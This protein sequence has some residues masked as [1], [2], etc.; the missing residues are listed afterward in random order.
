MN[1]LSIQYESVNHEVVLPKMRKIL[2]KTNQ[3][4]RELMNDPESKGK[5]IVWA[6]LIMDSLSRHSNLN[7][8]DKGGSTMK[9]FIILLLAITSLPTFSFSGD[10]GGGRSLVVPNLALRSNPLQISK[11]LVIPNKNIEAVISQ[12]GI[13]FRLIDIQEGFERF[14]GIR[15]DRQNTILNLNKPTEVDVH[16]IILMDGSII[17]IGDIYGK[18]GGDMGGG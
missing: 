11:T 5:D 18:H 12:D 8:R 10:M 13:Y 17:D 6:G 9:A 16:T 7:I 1:W 4:I 3:D 15:I 14:N 2:I